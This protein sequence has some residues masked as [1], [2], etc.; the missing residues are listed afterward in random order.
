MGSES[1]AA[2][3]PDGGGK[4]VDGGLELSDMGSCCVCG[5]D[6]ENIKGNGFGRPLTN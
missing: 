5:W 4:M 3:G 2:V 6:N 1:S